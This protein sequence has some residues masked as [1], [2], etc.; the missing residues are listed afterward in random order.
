MLRAASVHARILPLHSEQCTRARHMPHPI[1]CVYMRTRNHLHRAHCT[2]HTPQISLIYLRLALFVFWFCF[3]CP[4]SG[5]EAG[6]RAEHGGTVL[7]GGALAGAIGEA[8]GIE[9]SGRKLV[10]GRRRRY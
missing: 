9:A 2:L 8:G 5:R 4:G 3:T 1:Y 7:E 6:S 10:G